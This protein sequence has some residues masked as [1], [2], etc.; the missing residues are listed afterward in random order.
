[1]TEQ[2]LIKQ[3]KLAWHDNEC[4]YIAIPIYST[5]GT[6]LLDV[7][8]YK[9]GKQW[10]GRIW[11]EDMIQLIELAGDY[12]KKEVKDEHTEN[13]AD[14]IRQDEAKKCAEHYLGIMRDA[15]EQATLKER[16]ACAKLCEDNGGDDYVMKAAYWCADAIRARGKE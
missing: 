10:A 6:H 12:S 15:V 14:L 4:K 8:F 7:L 5:D 16:E 11:H 9:E 2:E 1:M 13:F 3:A